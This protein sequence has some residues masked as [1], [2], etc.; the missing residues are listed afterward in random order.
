MT[1]SVIWGEYVHYPV[2][3]RRLALPAQHVKAAAEHT[4]TPTKLASPTRTA[5]PLTNQRSPL[6]VV[7][8]AP[9]ETMQPLRLQD[10]RSP[11]ILRYSPECVEEAFS[12]VRMYRILG[13]SFAKPR[14]NP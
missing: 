6:L 8:A 9:L 7:R 2:P 3:Q 10:S 1:E 13:S 14:S 4:T 5:A 11:I 12:E